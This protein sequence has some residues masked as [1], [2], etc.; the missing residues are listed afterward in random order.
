MRKVIRIIRTSFLYFL[1]FILIIC[2]ALLL[3]ARTSFFQ[4]WL[5]QQAT[6]YLSKELNTT[7]SIG[8]VKI[9]FFKEAVLQDVLILDL[10]KDTLLFANELNASIADFDYKNQRLHIKEVKLTK[11]YV[12]LY[13]PKQDSSFNFQFLADYFS[14]GEEKKDTSK[15]DWDIKLRSISLNDVRFAYRNQNK[16]Q[17]ADGSINYDNL[18]VSH[19][20]GKFKDIKLD[21][22]KIYTLIEG[23][24][25]SEQCGFSLLEMDA[26][27]EISSKE[28]QLCNLVLRTPGTNL[29]GNIDFI[30]DG[31]EAYDDF[32]NKV[33]LNCNLHPQTRV[34]LKDISFF[35]PELQGLQDTLKISGNVSGYVSDLN[36]R[37]IELYY[38]NNTCFKGD[39]TLT[40]L[41]DIESSYLH[42]DS[43]KLSTSFFDLIQ[44]PEYPFKKGEK[45]K[46][47]KDVATLGVISYEGKFDGL[48]NDF[49]TYG[50]IKTAL[51]NFKTDLSIKT[52]E[53]A[54]DMEYSGKLTTSGFN[55]GAYAKNKDLGSLNME[56]KIK[57]KGVSIDKINAKME[58]SIHSLLYK[59]YE[60]HKIKIDGSFAKKT[61][62]GVLIS[63]DPNADFDFNGTVNF[64]NKLPQ[65]DFISTV[66]KIDLYKL[67]LTS[68]PAQLSTQI[69]INLNGDNIDNL[70]GN[71]NFDD[72]Y[73]KNNDKTYKISTFD[74]TLNQSA[75]EKKIHLTSNYFN[76]DMN[77]PFDFSNLGLA[78]NQIMS[79][80]YPTFFDKNKGKKI[81]KDYFSYKVLIKKYDIIHELLTPSL[82]F[83]PQSVISGEFDAGKN[84]INCNL[85]SSLVELGGVKFNQGI[86][87]SYSRNNK[88]NLVFKSNKVDL[89]DSI[90]LQNYF[91]YVVSQDLNTKYNAEWDNKQTPATSGQIKGRIEFKKESTTFF[92]D[93]FVITNR[94]TSWTLITANPT[95]YDSSGV[96]NVN[97]L[98]FINQDQGIKV[99]GLISNSKKDSVSLEFMNLALRQFNPLLASYKMKLDGFLNG[100]IVLHKNEGLYTVNSFLDFTRFKLNDILIGELVLKT[101]YLNKEKT[102]VIDGYTSLGLVDESGREMKNIS[103]KGN[104]FM[105]RKEESIDI[106]FIASP[107]NLK[108]A[109][110]FI[111]GI[112]TVNNG[113]ANGSG[114]I[115]GTPSEI[116]IDGALK[117]YKSDIKV[118]YTNV[119]YLI[120]GDVE[121][122]PDQIRFSDLLMS[123]KGLKAA[124]QGTVNGNI[125]HNNFKNMQ[126]DYDITYRNM[127]ILNTTE[128]QNK[129]FYGKIYGSGNIGIWGF[130]NNLNMQIFDTTKKNSRFVLPLDG[131]AE[132]AESDFI[133]FVKR[134]TVNKTV[135]KPITGFNLDLN[136]IATPDL[137]TKIIFD[138][139][140]GDAINVF[141]NGSI[142]MR[143]NTLGKFDMFGEYVI[144]GGDYNFSLE[145]VINKKFDIDPGSSI[146]WSGNPMNADI[147]IVASY[148]QR[149]SIAPLVND[150][151]GEHKSR[152][153]AYCKL[154]M[155]NK[156]M[157]PDISFALEFPSIADN[158]RSQI[159][160]VLTD[161]QELNRQVF[162][163]LLF[164]SFVPPLIY[165][166]SGGG[167]TAGNAAA[168]TGSELL[169]NRLNNMLGSMM[170]N[171]D[172][173]LQVGV[174]YR[175]GSQT[176]S[177][178]VLLNVS[179]NFFDDKLSVDG[180]FGVGNNNAGSRNYIG[181]VNI[182]YKL[183]NDGRYRLKGFN[184]TNDNTQLI[185]TG[186]LYTQGVGFFFREEFNSFEELY[187]RYLKKIKGDKKPD[188]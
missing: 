168:S 77:G 167:V 30:H 186:G 119:S 39:I 101:D 121:I 145:K 72:T 136:I 114:K 89:V 80:Y 64:S 95:V 25:F 105:E 181:D 10:K 35:V 23:L 16:N 87:E 99:S 113:F 60:Y 71:I 179:R 188:S 37:N 45:L 78:F 115:H 33:K 63:S 81:Y 52:G 15:K 140:N 79:N 65:M 104:Y 93:N 86:I 4:T 97:P 130:L 41:P 103:F 48:I 92:Y 26:Y 32:I 163:F 76:F 44:I 11:S 28:I 175:P 137:Q 12:N 182:E 141:G 144:S 59:G 2:T 156:L 169:S 31:W 111:E 85:K 159:N 120:T 185:T 150:V 70:T 127:L 22:D 96:I 109:N 7:L 133:E 108:L 173:D 29:I 90:S 56:V 61:F 180:N 20:K 62:N 135:K 183:S 178:E 68:T 57:G 153:P 124:P 170:G 149:A 158:V 17:E 143:I 118:D 14:G 106:D 34:F 84:I 91:M 98:Y 148:R 66:N 102:L 157:S 49:T 6:A 184:R 27:A 177:D 165:N 51:G 46:I 154:K 83:S 3:L 162:S 75:I 21:K 18:L 123:E 100:N 128:K 164:R 110:P 50:V 107:L 43:K 146:V 126:L 69:L 19:L 117:V 58:G 38:L 9:R 166:S 5:A 187:R 172:R 171:L 160:S 1:L 142:N 42:F 55:L 82:K 67:H 155:K 138:K 147:D 73:F 122:M 36:L 13:I 54:D 116:K 129:D 74:L 94:D 152:T 125:F 40:G 139:V 88:I 161:E 174:N 151:T 132:I 24:S 53:K 131:P 112:L 8:K 134:D 47:T 176:N